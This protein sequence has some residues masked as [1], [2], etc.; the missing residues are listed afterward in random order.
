ML[1]LYVLLS[2][3]LEP[4]V[5]TWVGHYPTLQQDINGLTIPKVYPFAEIK[6]PNIL[7]NN[8][9]SDNNLLTID[10]W[11]NLDTDITE[12]EGICDE[13]HEALNY[14]HEITPTIAVSITRDRPYKL[15]IPD[16]DINIQRRQ[17]RYVVNI[18]AINQ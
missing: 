1:D 3:I 4:I 11:N 9:Y 8:R 16:P 10:I 15:E 6:F 12:I 13:I 2:S 14:M 18:Y 5:P 7:P 17:L